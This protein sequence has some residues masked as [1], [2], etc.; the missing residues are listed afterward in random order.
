M[1]KNK[2]PLYVVKQDHVEEATSLVDMLFKK[3][4]IE[5]VLE[6]LFN[7]FEALFKTVRS[8]DSFVLVKNLFD[9][10]ISRFELFKRYS[11]L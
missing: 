2:N 11:I 10:L 9:E 1:K 4:N 3:L 6:F 7:L 8:Y 5:P